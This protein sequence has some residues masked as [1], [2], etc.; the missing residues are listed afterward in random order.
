MW[1]DNN[2]NE[3]DNSF[4]LLDPMEIIIEGLYIG[5][6]FD[7]FS[8]PLLNYHLFKKFKLIAMDEFDQFNMC[9]I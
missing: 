6:Y 9:N 1:A 3:D 5:I 7:R 2:L 8:K 4:V